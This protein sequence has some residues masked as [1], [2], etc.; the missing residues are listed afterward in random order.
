MSEISF[1]KDMEFEN[2]D[3]DYKEEPKLKNLMPMLKKVKR[4]ENTGFRQLNYLFQESWE[5]L[6]PCTDARPG[7]PD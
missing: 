6:H 2:G 7:L 3:T 1:D 5:L 4:G